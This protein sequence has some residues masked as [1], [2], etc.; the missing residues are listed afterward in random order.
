ML[1]VFSC[2]LELLP[3]SV[4]FS[5]KNFFLERRIYLLWSHSVFVYLGMRLLCFP[6]WRLVLL[7]IGLYVVWYGVWVFVV[8]VVRRGF[9]NF[10]CIFPLHLASIVSDEK[11]LLI[12]LRFPCDKLIFSCCS[13]ENLSFSAFLLN[14]TWEW[15]SLPWS[16]GEFMEISEWAD[17]HFSLNLETLQPLFLWPFPALSCLRSSSGARI[18]CALGLGAVLRASVALFIPFSVFLLHSSGVRFPHAE[19][20]MR[21]KEEICGSH[22]IDSCCSC[23]IWVIFL[24]FLHLPLVQVLETLHFYNFHQLGLCH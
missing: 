9:E 24:N 7:C 13:E 6:V 17:L 16:C 19:L 2:R 3:G 5:L 20:E 14:C 22:A 15:P 1:F 11:Q 18:V 10:G 12:F 21:P 23:W 8:V 4:A